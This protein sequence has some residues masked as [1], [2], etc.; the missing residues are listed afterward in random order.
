MSKI[1]DSLFDS[2]QVNKKK[3]PDDRTSFKKKIWCAANT[4][5]D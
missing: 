4:I 2:T 5:L 1:T 3:T